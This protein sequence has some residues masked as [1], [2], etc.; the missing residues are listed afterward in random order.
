MKNMRQMKIRG[1]ITKSHFPTLLKLFDKLLSLTGR[2][3]FWQI[4]AF[5]EFPTAEKSGHVPKSKGNLNL[6]GYQII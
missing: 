3:D 2:L 1:L 6:H 5:P 4:A